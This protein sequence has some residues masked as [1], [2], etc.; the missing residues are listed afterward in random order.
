MR[1]SRKIRLL[2]LALLLMFVWISVA[3]VR[4]QWTES[5]LSTAFG[6][7][8]PALISSSIKPGQRTVYVPLVPLL[9][10]PFQPRPKAYLMVGDFVGAQIQ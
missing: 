9:L 5:S 8:K 6:L 10:N 3:V 1:A 4:Q 7:T 2:L